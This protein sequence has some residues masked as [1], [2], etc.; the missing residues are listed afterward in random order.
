MIISSVFCNEL[1]MIANGV[2]VYNVEMTA[3]YDVGTVAT[4]SCNQGY[5][6]EGSEMRTCE[7]AGDGR[8]KRFSGQAPICELRGIAMIMC[9][10]NIIH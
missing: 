5:E 3:P 4:Y 9:S 7:D 2:I 10:H 8:G 1:E 6:L